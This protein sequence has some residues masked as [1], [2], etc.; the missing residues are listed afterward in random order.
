M[1]AGLGGWGYIRMFCNHTCSS[2]AV[3][4]APD[5]NDT[6]IW[7]KPNWFDLSGSRWWNFLQKTEMI[8]LTTTE[9]PSR[10]LCTQPKIGNPYW[11]A[12][13]S[14][15]ARWT[16]AAARSVIFFFFFFPFLVC[17]CAFVCFHPHFCELRLASTGQVSLQSVMAKWRWGTCGFW[18][19]PMIHLA[20]YFSILWLV[21]GLW[22]KSSRPQVLSVLSVSPTSQCSGAF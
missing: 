8:C 19:V 4:T 3:K 17:V 22:R 16:S 10:L 6:Y 2:L 1:D 5:L 13:I 18:S 21:S 9:H 7:N 15:A 11:L 20:A 12:A 14:P